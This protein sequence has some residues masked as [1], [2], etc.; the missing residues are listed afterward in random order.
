M[1]QPP[2]LSPAPFHLEGGPIS[3]LLIHGFTGAPPEMRLLADYLHKRGYTVSVPLLPG[4]GTTPEDMNQQKWS[5]WADHA[6]KAL[7]VLRNQSEAV[8]V[9]GLSMGA[10]LTLYLA[11]RHAEIAGA[12]VYSPA[13]RTRS[14]SVHL[15]PLAKHLVSTLPKEKE[16]DLVDPDALNL[17]WSYPVYPVAAA[18]ELLKLQRAVRS[19]LPQITCPLLIMHSTGDKSIHPRSAQLV[20]ENINS[21]QK[22]LITLNGSGHCITVDR[23]WMQV[24]DATSQ[25]IRQQTPRAKGGA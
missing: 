10:L 2:N 11:A 25:F 13:L 18:H 19:S 22:D 20:Y 12:M 8:F 3:V 14:R 15:T 9:G 23:E 7:A 4:H 5:D 16:T 21:Q 1:T 6:D 24:A 17:L